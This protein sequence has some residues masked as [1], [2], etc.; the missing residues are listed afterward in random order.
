MAAP[1]LDEKCQA[2]LHRKQIVVV[3][4]E[5]GYYTGPVTQ[6]TADGASLVKILSLFI[7]TQKKIFQFA[8]I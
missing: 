1:M 3:K 4:N 8:E 6:I 7:V 2:L 5:V